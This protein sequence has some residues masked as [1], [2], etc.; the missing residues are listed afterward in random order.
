MFFVNVFE[1]FQEIEQVN[2]EPVSW[3]LIGRLTKERDSYHIFANHRHAIH[4]SLIMAF[5]SM[6]HIDNI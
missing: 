6:N 4:S 1:Q 3:V 2:R 5:L